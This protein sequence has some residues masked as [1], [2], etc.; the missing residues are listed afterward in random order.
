PATYPLSLHAALPISVRHTGKAPL[1]GR[2]EL[3]EVATA[4]LRTNAGA[5]WFAKACA[6]LYPQFAAKNTSALEKW[7]RENAAGSYSAEY[8]PDRKSTR[9]NSSHVKI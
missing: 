5:G 6:D 7:K 1:T 9:L 4:S 3:S 8:R 2:F